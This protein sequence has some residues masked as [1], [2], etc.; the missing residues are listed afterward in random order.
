MRE[1]CNTHGRGE[2]GVQNFNRKP[3]KDH[4]DKYNVPNNG[5][6]STDKTIAKQ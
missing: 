5:I 3:Q 1:A 4:G 2:K 6:T